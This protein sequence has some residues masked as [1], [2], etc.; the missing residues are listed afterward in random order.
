MGRGEALPTGS[1][2]RASVTQK[3]YQNLDQQELGI[4]YPRKKTDMSFT[5]QHN[6][7]PEYS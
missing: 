7:W 2:I 5:Q 1:S 4:F 3:D 6:Q